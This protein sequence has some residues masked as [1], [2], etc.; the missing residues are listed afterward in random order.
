MLPKE[1]IKLQ[2][3]RFLAISY[4]LIEEDKLNELKRLM[5]KLEI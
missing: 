3:L 4:D 1:I 2:N 5:P